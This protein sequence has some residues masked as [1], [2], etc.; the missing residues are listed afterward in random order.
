NALGSALLLERSSLWALMW[1]GGCWCQLGEGPGPFAE[2]FAGAVGIFSGCI[3][4]RPDHAHA[5][6]WRA[7]AYTGLRRSAD[8][9][10]D[11]ATAIE[12]DPK[13]ADAWNQRGL[14]YCDH[15]APFDKAVADFSQAIQLQPDG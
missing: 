6:Y 4:R 8:A 1:L 14:I 9:L 15:L 5:Y 3:L 2:H 10:A 11:L 7:G 12:L 13:R